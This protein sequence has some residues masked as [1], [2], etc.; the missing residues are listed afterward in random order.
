MNH[1][2]DLSAMTMCEV[3]MCPIISVHAI[4]LITIIAGWLGLLCLDEV[5]LD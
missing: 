2:T 4:D 5:L 3:F 1:G